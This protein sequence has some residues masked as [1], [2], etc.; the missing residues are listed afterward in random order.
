M[1]TLIS[2]DEAGAM[3]GV[4][5][6]RIRSLLRSAQ[7]R[8]ML[9]VVS[10]RPSSYSSMRGDSDV[11]RFYEGQGSHQDWHSERNAALYRSDVEAYMRNNGIKNSQPVT[12][13]AEQPTTVNATM[14]EESVRAAFSLWASIVTEKKTDW[15]EKEFAGA[16]KGRCPNYHTK[17]LS[18]AWSL[19]PSDYKHGP[20]KPKT[21]K[22][23]NTSE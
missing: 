12:T 8:E 22:T 1:S 10:T 23:S 16:L 17:V 19:L 5:P 14:W 7:G 18:L 13:S 9:P 2:I 11:L 6:A 21:V 15:K 4:S 20:G 3:L